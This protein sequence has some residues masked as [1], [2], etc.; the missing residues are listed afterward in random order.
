MDLFVEVTNLTKGNTMWAHYT[1]TGYYPTLIRLSRQIPKEN[2]HIYTIWYCFKTMHIDW[3][4]T[5]VTGISG[6]KI[7]MPTEAKVSIFT[8]NDLRHINDDHFE[9]NLVAHLLNQIYIV[10]VPVSRYDY[11]DPHANVID[12]PTPS[13]STGATASPLFSFTA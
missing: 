13:T 12:E 5:V 3:D 8:D 7:D 6:I 10:P 4:N 9:I 11:D 2:V 1:L